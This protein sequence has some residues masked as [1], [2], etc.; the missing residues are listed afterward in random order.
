V[1][2]P[3]EPTIGGRLTL[4]RGGKSQSAFAREIGVHKNTLGNYERGD[5]TPDGGFLTRLVLAGFN[6][7]WVLTGDG[8]MLLADLEAS[9]GRQFDRRL[10]A[11]VIAAVRIGL[12]RANRE[13]APE[14]EAELVLAFYDLFEHERAPDQEKLIRLVQSAA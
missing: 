11:T 8:P 5:R 10:M 7:N 1:R 6:A 13:M 14:D 2:T 4:I 12:E 3:E 9:G